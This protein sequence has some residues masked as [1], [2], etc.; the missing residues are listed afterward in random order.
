MPSTYNNGISSREFLLSKTWHFT[1]EE[2]ETPNRTWESNPLPA[3]V[4]RSSSL[5][6]HPPWTTAAPPTERL[7]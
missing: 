2:E 3:L 6:A 1:I 4:R 7:D 5:P